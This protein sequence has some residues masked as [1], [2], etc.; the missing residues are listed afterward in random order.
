MSET[1]GETQWMTAE[2]AQE[3]ARQAVADALAQHQSSS[4]AGVSGTITAAQARALI[5]EALARQ[6]EQHQEDIK[7]L[8][9][10]LRGSVVTYVPYNAGGPGTEIAETWGAYDQALAHAADDARRQQAAAEIK[11]EKDSQ[12]TLDSLFPS[13]NA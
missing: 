3:V 7:S 10:S 2:Q 12:P 4:G 5:D 6:A 9:A 8:A 11:K 1:T 13:V